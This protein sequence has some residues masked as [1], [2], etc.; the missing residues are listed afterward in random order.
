MLQAARLAAIRNCCRCNAPSTTHTAGCS[1]LGLRRCASFGSGCDW[2]QP[3]CPSSPRGPGECPGP[4]PFGFAYTFGSQCLA[5]R[6]RCCSKCS[7]RARTAAACFP[8]RASPAWNRTRCT[9]REQSARFAD[10]YALPCSRRW[11]R[12]YL[13][14]SRDPTTQLGQGPFLAI[15]GFFRDHRLGPNCLVFLGL[16][17]DFPQ[18]FN[19]FLRIFAMRIL[20][21]RGECAWG[22]QEAEEQCVG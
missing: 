22:R 2:P 10:P 14:S 8:G 21:L 16:F 20:L 17:G 18:R 13:D 19:R 4:R 12:R 7:I 6:P 9:S 15:E 3:S 11:P 1:D 5:A